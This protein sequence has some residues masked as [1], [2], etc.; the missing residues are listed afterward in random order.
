MNG[1]KHVGVSLPSRKQL[2]N[3]YNSELAA[4][5]E[6]TTSELLSKMPLIDA[7]SDV[8]SKKYCEDGDAL[9]NI[10][11][12]ALDKAYFHDAINCSDMRKDA[13]A[14]VAFLERS[15]KDL[16]GP[17][18]DDMGRLAGWVLHNTKANGRAMLMMQEKHP[19]L[20][21]RG[22][23]VHGL[24][25]C[26]KDFCKHR[27]ATGPNAHARTYGLKWA[28]QV[29]KDSNTVA[30]YLQDSGVA[31]KIVSSSSALHVHVVCIGFDVPHGWRQVGGAGGNLCIP[32]PNPQLP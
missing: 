8:W 3:K 20:I 16:V 6:A 26:M 30:N 7:S 14:I 11:A 2:P 17:N 19:K 9:M 12:L 31:R 15:S 1:L 24:S 22:C 29:V 13:T 10:M 23:F 27:N 32:S 4:E 28:E 5:A 25:L 21:M 18:E